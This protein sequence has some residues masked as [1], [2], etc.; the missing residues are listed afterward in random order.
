MAP[1]YIQSPTFISSKE[2]LTFPAVLSELL[3]KH[4]ST[5]IYTTLWNV[6][7]GWIL[8]LS[9][10]NASDIVCLAFGCEFFIRKNMVISHR[11]F[12]SED[13]SDVLHADIFPVIDQYLC[14]S[15]SKDVSQ[16]FGHD[17]PFFIC[18]FCRIVLLRDNQL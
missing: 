4:T 13:I 7:P 17:R 3:R 1:I 2:Q 6:R 10:F 8:S 18:S 14:A 9:V 16:D 15:N 12:D 5:S 11:S